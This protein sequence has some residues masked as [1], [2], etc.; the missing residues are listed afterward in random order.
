MAPAAATP[1]SLARRRAAAPSDRPKSHRAVGPRTHCAIRRPT[2]PRTVRSPGRTSD[3][4]HVRKIHYN[5][6][7]SAESE[8]WR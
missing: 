4:Q 1:R 8:A 2:S 3:S 7:F 6:F 5:A